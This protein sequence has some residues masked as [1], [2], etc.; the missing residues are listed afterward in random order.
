MKKIFLF[1]V[2][3]LTLTSCSIEDDGPG[4]EYEFAQVVD[5]DLP[6]VFELGESYEIDVTYLRP[7]ACHAATGLE[8]NR[9]GIV[10]EDR[11]SIYIVGVA[12]S[13]ADRVE[14]DRDAEEAELLKNGSFWLTIDE[15]EP[16]TFYLWT[17][18]NDDMES[19]YVTVEVPVEEMN[20]PGTSE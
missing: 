10:G 8:V 6:E 16:Y 9:R 17:G 1:L 14:C 13:E 15:A 4:I 7:S 19:T 18:F 11:R 3:T 5:A 20:A 12:S 2:G